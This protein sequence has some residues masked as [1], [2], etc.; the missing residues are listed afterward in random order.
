MKGR[1]CPKTACTEHQEEKHGKWTYS[2]PLLRKRIM[3]KGKVKLDIWLIQGL[4]GY[5]MDLRAPWL[6]LS[7]V[8]TNP[9]ASHGFYFI[10]GFHRSFKLLLY[11]T[12][13]SNATT[14][15]KALEN[16]EKENL[17]GGICVSILQETMVHSR[18]WILFSS[19]LPNISNSPTCQNQADTRSA[20]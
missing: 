6:K 14:N 1:M 3:V 16:T 5:I 11:S 2:F 4:T 18:V 12:S 8:L 19:P 10:S 15:V 17:S 13:S 7:W 20:N 9:A